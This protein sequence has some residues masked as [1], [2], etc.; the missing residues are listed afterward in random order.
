MT[1]DD[2]STVGEIGREAG[3]GEHGIEHD[4]TQS[5]S[6]LV[7]TSTPS[8]RARSRRP[9]SRAIG[10]TENGA[11]R[12]NGKRAAAPPFVPSERDEGNGKATPRLPSST[13]K[14]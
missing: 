7:R 5:D 1:V 12:R 14:R 8:S 2:A 13:P 3:R 10:T 11:G 4:A 9:P 6:A